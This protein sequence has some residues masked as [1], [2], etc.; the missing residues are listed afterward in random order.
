MVI[1]YTI[2]VNDF[3]HVGHLTQ[4]TITDNDKQSFRLLTCWRIAD[5]STYS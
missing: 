3:F 4:L 2:E 1:G 5:E